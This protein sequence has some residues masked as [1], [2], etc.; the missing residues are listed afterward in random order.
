M[1]AQRP[2]FESNLQSVAKYL[3]RLFL[4][5]SLLQKLEVQKQNEKKK[6][7]I[8]NLLPCLTEISAFLSFLWLFIEQKCALWFCKGFLKI[9][10]YKLDGGKRFLLW[11][12]LKLF[13]VG[14]SEFLPGRKNTGRKP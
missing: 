11:V 8:I 2:G 6:L 5:Y 4:V 1:A 3:L 14:M 7:H 13:G 9:A 10:Y 12:W